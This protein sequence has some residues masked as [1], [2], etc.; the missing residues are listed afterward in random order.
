MPGS[1]ID[2]VLSPR[3]P[4][5]SLA[6]VG[7]LETAFKVS[8]QSAARRVITSETAPRCAG[9]MWKPSGKHWYVVSPAFQAEG[10]RFMHRRDDTLPCDCVTRVCIDGN[11]GLDTALEGA[12]TAA[13]WFTAVPLGS[14]RDIILR[15]EAIRL[16]SY[17]VF[18]FLAPLV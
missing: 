17:G 4:R 6:D 12:T 15:E 9:I 16:G 18:T 1:R 11:R 5:A 10:Y 14:A 3:R 8:F 2:S 7:K 13:Y